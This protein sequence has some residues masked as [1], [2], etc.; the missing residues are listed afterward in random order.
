MGHPGG[1]RLAPRDGAHG[2]VWPRHGD[3]RGPAGL[4]DALRDR[5]FL[6]LCRERRCLAHCGEPSL[7]VTVDA[8]PG[9]R[10]FRLQRREAQTA[11]GP[12][13]GPWHQ[14]RQGEFCRT[15]AR[16][17]RWARRRRDSRLGGRTGPDRQHFSARLQ[18]L[19]RHRRAISP[20]WL[21]DR[22]ERPVGEE[23]LAPRCHPRR[24]LLNEYPRLHPTIADMLERVAAG[25]LT[26]TIDRTFPLADAAAAHAYIES[27][28]AFGRAVLAP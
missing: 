14:L 13:P 24:V 11:P 9:A 12:R 28:Q 6:Q 18:R 1:T 17:D 7:S 4:L 8:T 27:R 3:C 23:Q 21:Q 10:P 15:N 26:V 16:A 20:L 5:G 19:A 25:E 22:G 2:R